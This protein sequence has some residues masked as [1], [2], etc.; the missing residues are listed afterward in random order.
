[1]FEELLYAKER[2]KCFGR[3]L[4]RSCMDGHLLEGRPSIANTSMKR[5]FSVTTCQTFMN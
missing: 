1:M 5:I 4:G 3:T 2:D